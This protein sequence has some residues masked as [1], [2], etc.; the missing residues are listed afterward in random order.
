VPSLDYD[1]SNRDSYASPLAGPVVPIM[2]APF[3]RSGPPALPLAE[4][5]LDLLFFGV[6]N[7]RRANLLAAIESGPVARSRCSTSPCS[8]PS[9][10]SSSAQSKAVLNLHHYELARFEQIR[11]AHCLSLGHAG[12]F[13]THARHLARGAFRERGLLPADRRAA[14]IP[15]RRFARPVL[16]GRQTDVARLQSRDPLAAV[17]RTGRLPAIGPARWCARPTTETTLAMCRMN[18]GSGKESGQLVR[19]A[20]RRP[21]SRN[22]RGRGG[23]RAFRNDRRAEREAMRD[24]DLLEAGQLV[25]MQVQH[26]LRLADE[27]IALGSEQGLV[28]QRDLATGRLDRCQQVGAPV[29]DDAEEQQV[30]GPLGQRQRRRA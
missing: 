11:V 18:L 4:R 2:D 28:E 9:A 14:P 21:R 6:V 17:R 3:L 8:D 7:D 26:G 25:V 12:H 22:A 5:P 13:G 16:F 10:I 15:R 30:Q 24:P 27:L 1:P 20:G 19:S 29:V 23:G